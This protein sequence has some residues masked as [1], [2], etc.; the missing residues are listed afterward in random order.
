M[1]IEQRVISNARPRPQAAGKIGA[2]KI[3][4]KEPEAEAPEKK[5]RKLPKKAI[6]AVV[7]VAVLGGAGYAAFALGLV[8]GGGSAE[9][10]AP[11]KPVPGKVLEVEPISL[12]LA[13]GHYLRVGLGLQLTKDVVEAP[14]PSRALDLAIAT[15]SGHTVGEVT[16]PATREALKDELVTQLGKA[17]EGE[18]MDVYLTNYVTQ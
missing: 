12:N 4:A 7:G 9:A 17:Y 11:E 15:F 2:G 5:A 6:L 18:V 3:G 13:D 14:D 10:A 8:G 1:P 16:D